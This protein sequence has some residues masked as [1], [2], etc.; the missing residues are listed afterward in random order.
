[1]TSAR[2]RIVSDDARARAAALSLL[3][4]VGLSAG[5]DGEAEVALVDASGP[6]A[7]PELAEIES[8]AQVRVIV[9]GLNA[10]RL[11]AHAGAAVDGALTP[12]RLARALAAAS[13]KRDSVEPAD[14]GAESPAPSERK[15]KALVAEDHPISREVLSRIL[16][17]M[18]HE[19]TVA[20]DGRQA[21][22]RVVEGDF[23]IVFMDVQMPGM[24]GLEATRRIRA[25]GGE[26]AR[27]PIVAMTASAM[28]FDRAACLEAGMT[29]ICRSRS[30]AT[31]SPTRWRKSRRGASERAQRCATGTRRP[32]SPL[33]P[34][35][36]GSAALRSSRRRPGRG[37]EPRLLRGSADGPLDRSRLPASRTTCRTWS[38]PRP[39]TRRRRSARRRRSCAT[40]PASFRRWWR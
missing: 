5:D 13:T 27:T 20:E 24:D 15:F 17:R 7:P 8:N 40:E 11:A 3:P 29:A 28:D 22:D 36:R 32:A 39:A 38:S 25:L 23:D 35:R 19:T 14:A 30:A 18:G 2:A 1:M 26:K 34:W 31:R 16:Q 21:V 4:Y 33:T 37:A 12:A 10:W 6:E 9:F